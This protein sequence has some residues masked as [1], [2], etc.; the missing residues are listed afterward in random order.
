[1]KKSLGKSNYK[2]KGN[3][4]KA[5]GKLNLFFLPVAVAIDFI[6]LISSSASAKED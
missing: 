6:N 3:M 2:E 1:L 5:R 4:K